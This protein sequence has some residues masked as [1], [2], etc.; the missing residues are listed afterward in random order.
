MDKP[1]I[2]SFQ[3]LGQALGRGNG[4][5]NCKTCGK[6]LKEGSRHETCFECHQKQTGGQQNAPRAANNPGA[7]GTNAGGGYTDPRLPAGYLANG[8]FLPSTDG[9][10]YKYLRDE[11]ITTHPL[12]LA[13]AFADVKLTTG[14]L[15]RFYG[16]ARY[17]AQRLEYGEPFEA[18]R[19]VI[20]ALEPMVAG[21]VG[22]AQSASQSRDYE[23]FKQFI[24]RNMTFAIQSREDYLQGFVPHF[25]YIVAYFTYFN[26][27]G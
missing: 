26:P 22:R 21:A 3:E 5:A 17:A 15:R 12:A 6:A 23:L 16:H 9:R 1:K 24:D 11:L 13:K 8:Y 20:L 25:Q 14:Q 4:V 2:T 27:K 10:G 19:P 7:G 18:V